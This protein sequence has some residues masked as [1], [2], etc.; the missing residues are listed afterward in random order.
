LENEF[1]SRNSE[2]ENQLPGSE[3]QLELEPTFLEEKII[4]FQFTVKMPPPRYYPMI[5]K[6]DEK[7]RIVDSKFPEIVY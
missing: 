4:P 2:H 5:L 1:I 6:R 3:S 7:G